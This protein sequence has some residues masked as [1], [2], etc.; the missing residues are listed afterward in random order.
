LLLIAKSLINA[1]RGDAR[2]AESVIEPHSEVAIV[3]GDALLIGE[4]IRQRKHVADLKQHR[5]G[6]GDSLCSVSECAPICGIEVVVRA[7]DRAIAIKT[8]GQENAVMETRDLDANSAIENARP[9]HRA[10]KEPGD[11]RPCLLRLRIRA[12]RAAEEDG[13]PR[14]EHVLWQ[15]L[16]IPNLMGGAMEIVES[17]R[18]PSAESGICQHNHPSFA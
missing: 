1:P 12:D 7:P 11:A 14:H 17:A 8:F 2:K 15:R 4:R 9:I 6:D 13:Q 10:E 18:N 16:D 5:I 3:I